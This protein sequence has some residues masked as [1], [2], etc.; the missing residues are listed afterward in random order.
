MKP[1]GT[2]VIRNSSGETVLGEMCGTC[3][4]PKT[5]SDRCGHSSISLTP[6]I[7]EKSFFAVNVVSKLVV[8]LH[9]KTLFEETKEL[10]KMDSEKLFVLHCRNCW[11]VIYS[12]DVTICGKCWKWVALCRFCRDSALR[13]LSEALRSE[14]SEEMLIAFQYA[15]ESEKGNHTCLCLQGKCLP[16][17]LYSVSLEEECGVCG[18][19][20]IYEGSSIYLKV[21]K[22]AVML[23]SAI[24]GTVHV[25]AYPELMR[26]SSE[27][28]LLVCH[29]C[30]Q[31]EDVIRVAGLKMSK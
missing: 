15:G 23:P 29:K 1:D 25:D 20:F 4:K 9:T 28:V 14:N 31:R 18:H 21:E 11:K 27:R 2:A 30:S 13:T 3:L 19:P 8:Y 24:C 12:D 26:F 6:S 7:G 22:G 10:V 5:G 17:V 16:F